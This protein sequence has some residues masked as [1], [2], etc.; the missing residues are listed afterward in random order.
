MNKATLG[1][2]AA[3]FSLPLTTAAALPVDRSLSPKAGS[4]PQQVRI[5]CDKY[6]RCYSATRREYR[7]RPRYYS[8]RSYRY[9]PPY[10][11]EYPYRYYYFGDPRVG[12]GIGPFGFGVW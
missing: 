8:Q 12:I 5:V 3:L 10:P 7:D 9:Y 4:H 1:L 6:R 11:Y 2:A